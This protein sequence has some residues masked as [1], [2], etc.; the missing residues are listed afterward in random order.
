MNNLIHSLMPL[1]AL[2]ATLL[3]ASGRMQHKYPSR[4]LQGHTELSEEVSYEL[5]RSVRAGMM[6]QEEVNSLIN[7]CYEVFSK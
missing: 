7:R 1:C 6:S 3:Y 5:D 2:V 4:P